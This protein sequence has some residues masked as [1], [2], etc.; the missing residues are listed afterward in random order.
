[1]PLGDVQAMRLARRIRVAPESARTYGALVGVLVV[2]KALFLLLPTVFPGADQDEAFSW[3]TIVSVS[4]AGL[5]GLVLTPRAGFPEM[6]DPR[7]SRRQRFVVPAIIGLVYGVETVLRDLA[8]PS[9]VHLRFPLSIPF[10][11]YGAILLEIMLRLF[12]VT[13]LTWLVS[14]VVLRGRGQAAAFWLAAVVAALY[15]PWPHIVEELHA[16]PPIATPGIFVQWA[17]QPLFVSNVVSA[18]VFR[19]YGFIAP[20]VMRLCFYLVWHI[21][22][23]GLLS[24]ALV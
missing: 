23:G 4:L 8:V 10:Y 15:E 14:N 20:L 7:V 1:M 19:R 2:V 12:A 5:I 24:R 18:Y 17:L 22:Y 6:W 3:A 11:A 13:A 9:P 21:L 16:S